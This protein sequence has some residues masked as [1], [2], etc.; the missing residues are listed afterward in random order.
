[1][2]LF[3]EQPEVNLFVGAMT[4]PPLDSALGYF[5]AL[6]TQPPAV[7]RFT[8]YVKSTERSWTPLKN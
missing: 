7:D 4:V 6:S 8:Y 1:M 2:T 5:M 3:G